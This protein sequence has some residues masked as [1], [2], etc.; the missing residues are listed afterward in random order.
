MSPDEILEGRCYRARRPACVHG[1]VNDRYAIRINRILG[2]VT[3]DGPA[4]A[5][6]RHYPTVSLETFA[7]WAKRDVTDELPPKEWAQWNFADPEKN[8]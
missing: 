8:K 3:Y 4:V 2:T 6:G 5:F 1:M 7:Q